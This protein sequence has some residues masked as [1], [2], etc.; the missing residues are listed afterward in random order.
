MKIV[1][2]DDWGG[3][4][5]SDK[6]VERLYS[7]GMIVPV[8]QEVKRHDPRLV[9]VVEELGE[10]AN[11]QFANLSIVEIDDDSYFIVDYDGLETVFTP[12]T[13]PWIMVE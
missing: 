2:N 5:L 8:S 4:G 11:G 7:L 12:T 13:A 3:F 9:K 1:I 6:A 10:E